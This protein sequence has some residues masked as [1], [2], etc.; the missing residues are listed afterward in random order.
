MK[1]LHTSQRPNRANSRE[2]DTI[3]STHRVHPPKCAKPPAL[4]T[5]YLTQSVRP[6]KLC[7]ATCFWHDLSECGPRNC[8][9]PPAFGTICLTQSVRPTKL[10]QAICSWHDLS[11]SKCAARETVPNHLL[12]ARFVSLKV[13]GS[14]N[15]AKPP[16]IGTICSTQSVQPA[17]LCQATCSWH[18]LSHSKCATRETMQVICYWHN[19]S[20]SKC[21][22]RE[23]VP[24]HLLLT[25]FVS[26]KVCGPRNC[27]KPPALDTIYSTQSVQPAKLC[28]ITCSWHDLSHSKCA[29]RET[30]PSHLLLAVVYRQNASSGARCRAVDIPTFL[31]ARNRAQF[32]FRP[33]GNIDTTVLTISLTTRC[34]V[35]RIII[36]AR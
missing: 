2:L 33:F 31:Q 8:A 9:K 13:C 15:C 16:A 21:A 23:T 27:A 36:G 18:D 30:V 26:L 20:H 25:R 28:Q 14:R 19:L 10:C 12:L 4:G 1:F 22:A 3:C 35:P 24:N 7:Q 11:H 5:I 6:A 29:A 34:D 17:K 32:I